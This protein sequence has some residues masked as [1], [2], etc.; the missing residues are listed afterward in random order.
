MKNKKAWIF[1]SSLAINRYERSKR[2]D[3]IIKNKNVNKNT[4]STKIKMGE[5]N[6]KDII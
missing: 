2:P 1:K 5:I 3:K 6:K 4:L